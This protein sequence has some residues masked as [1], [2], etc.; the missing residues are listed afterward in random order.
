MSLQV[1]GMHY[2]MVD[3]DMLRLVNERGKQ[4]HTWTINDADVMRRVLDAGV[5]G[6]VTNY[7]Q[8]ALEA[9]EYRLGMCGAVLGT[10]PNSAPLL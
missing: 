2:A 5:D 3:P 8:L 1:V 10:G 9:I 7:P 4:L 6:V